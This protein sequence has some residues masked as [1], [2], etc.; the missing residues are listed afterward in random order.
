MRVG[1][2]GVLGD[3]VL[4]DGVLGDGVLSDGVLAGRRSVRTCRPDIPQPSPSGWRQVWRRQVCRRQAGAQAAGDRSGGDRSGGDW[5]A[6]DS[7][8]RAAISPRATL[9]SSSSPGWTCSGPRTTVPSDRRT[10]AKPR[11]TTCCGDSDRA[12]R[13]SVSRRCWPKAETG[14]HGPVPSHASSR[15][16]QAWAT[17]PGCAH[18]S[19]S[20]AWRSRLSARSTPASRARLTSTRSNRCRPS[21]L[22]SAPP[23]RPP[24]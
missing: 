2:D 15:R 6:G 16:R 9:S 13:A 17:C 5:S 21:W 18:T 4:G 10:T 1:G 20:P 11:S 23:E 3:G 19:R 24:R 14:R 8:T 7:S 22:R 12:W